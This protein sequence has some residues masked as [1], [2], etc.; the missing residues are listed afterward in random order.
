MFRKIRI[1]VLSLILVVVALSAW[2]ADVRINSWNRT[3]NVAIYPVAADA[4]AQT[5]DFVR[6]LAVEDF[7]EIE[8]WFKGEAEG[9]GVKLSSDLVKIW[10]GPEVSEPPPVLPRTPGRVDAILYSLKLRW[11]ASRHDALD[12][13][14]KLTPAVRLFVLF[15]DAAPGVVL[16]HSV[17][18]S[19]GKIGV[20]HVFAHRQQ[21]RQNA[22]VI[23]HEL[24]HTFGATDKYA[25]ETLQPLF[26]EG[27]AEPDKTPLLPQREAEIMGG[28]IPL[29]EQDSVIPAGLAKTRIGTATAREIGLMSAK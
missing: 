3:V 22:V 27:Y 18:I 17:G 19:K 2:L 6:R 28:R 14:F 15:H 4:S 20:I 16:P 21:A 1:A 10:L 25:F 9:Y 11:W 5:R 12:T 13:P 26:P 7:G 8:Q 23:T 24:L 29:S